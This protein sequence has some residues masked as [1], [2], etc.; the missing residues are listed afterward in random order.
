[1]QFGDAHPWLVVG[2]A[3]LISLNPDTWPFSTVRPS[4]TVNQSVG[5]GLRCLGYG[6]AK[7]FELSCFS[8][9]SVAVRDMG[10]AVSLIKDS[11]GQTSDISNA[12]IRS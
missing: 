12:P 11:N 10:E 4:D 3:E 7:R 5:F 9:L 2:K 1:M 8:R 6:I